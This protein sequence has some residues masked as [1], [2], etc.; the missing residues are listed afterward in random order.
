MVL[1]YNLTLDKDVLKFLQEKL[2][3]ASKRI[4]F[5]VSRSLV[6]NSRKRILRRLRKAPSPNTQAD[7]PLKWRSERQRKFV[8]AKLRRENN[9]PYRRT[10]AMVAAWDVRG[11]SGGGNPSLEV[12][13]DS[14]QIDFVTGSG[15]VRQPM[16]ERWYEYQDILLEEEAKL[17]DTAID[18]LL[19]V[20]D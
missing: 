8:M 9:L 6:Q 2:K 15:D 13:N 11:S 20:L 16:F 17:T 3:T 14:P 7:Y 1:K 19:T 4:N 12:F 5:Y 10:G 18:Y